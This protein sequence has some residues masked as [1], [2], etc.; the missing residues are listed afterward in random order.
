MGGLIAAHTLRGQLMADKT[1][2]M[3]KVI[4]WVLTASVI[5]SSAAIAVTVA[6]STAKEAKVIAE[7]A[8][9][10]SSDNAKDFEYFKGKIEGTLKGVEKGMD[11]MVENHKRGL[12]N[13]NRDVDKLDVKI[14]EI[15]KIMGTFQRAD[16]GK[17]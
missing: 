10:A 12:D 7:R 1:M 15:I 2:N 11:V 17:R 14:D 4:G 8:E 3:L 16:D 9:A 6:T 13:I 5:M